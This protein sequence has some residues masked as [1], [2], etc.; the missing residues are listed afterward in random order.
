NAFAWQPGQLLAGVDEVGRGPLVGAV[1]TAA[2]ILDP[3]QPIAG[4]ADRKKLSDKKRTA[5]AQEIRH[6]AL[7]VS[8]GRADAAEVD[9]L[10]IYPPLLQDRKSTRLKS[11]HVSISYAVFCWHKKNLKKR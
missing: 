5:L 2:V 4:L 6:K 10:N 9:E 1:V 3:S 11:S 7:A 8:L